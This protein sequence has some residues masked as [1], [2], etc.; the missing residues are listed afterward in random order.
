MAD[1]EGTPPNAVAPLRVVVADDNALLREGIA[2]L[3]EEA[4]YEVVGRAVD[5][6]DLL[7]KVRSYSPD[8][9]I[10]DVRMPPTQTD[11]GLRAVHEIRRCY[12]DVVVLVL[13]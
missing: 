10:V 2:S 11:E 6:D 3:L 5:A 4:G 13:S 1:P 9:A 8:V 7:L 12:P